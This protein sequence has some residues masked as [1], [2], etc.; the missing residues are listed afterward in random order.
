MYGYRKAGNPSKVTILFLHGNLSNS[1]E[2]EP[3]MKRLSKAG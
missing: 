3:I 1:I 2:F